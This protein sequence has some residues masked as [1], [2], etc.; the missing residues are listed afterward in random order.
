MRFSILFKPVSGI[1][2]ESNGNPDVEN[3]YVYH[4]TCAFM[5]IVKTET[6]LA[7][8]LSHISLFE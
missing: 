8:I 6:L 3:I 7:K 2:K 5:K 4:K 1:T